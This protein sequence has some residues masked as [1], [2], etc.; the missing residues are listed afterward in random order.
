MRRK[1]TME[2]GTRYTFGACP[3][4]KHEFEVRDSKE[5]F[6]FK[7]HCKCCSTEICFDIIDGFVENIRSDETKTKDGVFTCGTCPSCNEEFLVEEG[8]DGAFE[9]KCESCKSAIYFDLVDGFV[10]NE[11]IK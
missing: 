9:I 4:C 6:G 11:R 2:S 7:R 8:P 1:I 10:E 3:E 5:G